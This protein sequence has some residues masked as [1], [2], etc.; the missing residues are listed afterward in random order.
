VQSF[1]NL[2]EFGRCVC[3]SLYT[4]NQLKA[5]SQSQA[6][7]HYIYY[8]PPMAYPK[9]MR[10]GPPKKELKKSSRSEIK[11]GQTPAFYFVEVHFVFWGA[12]P[13]HP[14]DRDSMIA[15]MHSCERSFCETFHRFGI[16]WT[17]WSI[18]IHY[19]SFK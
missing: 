19:N 7:L 9:R 4:C 16:T 17:P 18:W 8:N 6:L 13:I 3:E 11:W 10:V 14:T 5:V 1:G 15:K 2:M 12:Q